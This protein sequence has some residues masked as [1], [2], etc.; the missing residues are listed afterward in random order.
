MIYWDDFFYGLFKP[1]KDACFSLILTKLLLILYGVNTATSVFGHSFDIRL[2][3]L[4]FCIISLFDDVISSV[5]YDFKKSSCS[6]FDQGLR[7]FGIITGMVFFIGPLTFI[8]AEG[9]GS[10]GE[11]V[12]SWFI[13]L[14]ILIITTAI[15]SKISTR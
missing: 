14:M 12:I 5:I 3:T 9:G 8:Y 15:R 7:L 6:P 13:S 1:I 4:L 2:F 11:A 10:F